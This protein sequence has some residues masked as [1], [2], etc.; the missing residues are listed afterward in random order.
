MAYRKG[1][2]HT[3]YLVLFAWRVSYHVAYPVPVLYC[4]GAGVLGG[5]YSGLYLEVLGWYK[6]RGTGNTSTI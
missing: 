5:R 1:M 2:G 6:Q 3:L 4:F